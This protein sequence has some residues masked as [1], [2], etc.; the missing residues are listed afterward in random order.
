MTRTIHTTGY[1]VH[2][3]GECFWHRT[4]KAAQRR[5]SKAANS[6]CPDAQIIECSTGNL[7]A[8]RAQ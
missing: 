4:L 7:V 1:D 5:Y 3:F 8:G 2:L 6:Y